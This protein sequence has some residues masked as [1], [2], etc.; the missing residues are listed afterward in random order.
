MVKITNSK[1]TKEKNKRYCK[2][3]ESLEESLKEIKLDREG[4]IKL[5]TWDEFIKE[6]KH[7]KEN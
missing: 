6:L 3:Y 5:E 7:S 4:K 1:F 2:V